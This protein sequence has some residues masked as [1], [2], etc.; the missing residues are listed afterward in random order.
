[1]LNSREFFGGDD[2]DLTTVGVTFHAID[3][4]CEKQ[5][6]QNPKDEMA[7]HS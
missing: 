7:Y 3:D 6:I 1:M 5:R 4:L 2:E